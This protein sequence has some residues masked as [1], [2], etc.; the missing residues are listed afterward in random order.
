MEHT[1]KNHKWKRC[2]K[3]HKDS[4]SFDREQVLIMLL[5]HLGS[6]GVDLDLNATCQE[7]TRQLCLPSGLP[8][9]LE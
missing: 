8:L 7:R 9:H 4:V 5:E 1:K 6:T 2:I 3:F